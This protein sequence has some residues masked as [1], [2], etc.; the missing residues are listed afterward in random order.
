M[1]NPGLDAC[2]QV[3]KQ[4]ASLPSLIAEALRKNDFVPTFVIDV[5]NIIHAQLHRHDLDIVLRHSWNGFDQGIENILKTHAGWFAPFVPG[6]TI[7]KGVC[8]TQEKPLPNMIYVFD[9]VRVTDKRVNSSRFETRATAHLRIQQQIESDGLDSEFS[10]KDIGSAVGGYNIQAIDRVR[11]ILNRLG[12][13]HIQALAEAEHEM[14]I[15]MQMGVAQKALSYDTDFTALLLDGVFLDNKGSC[16]MGVL[17]YLPKLSAL[18]EESTLSTLLNGAGVCTASLMDTQLAFM[19]NKYNLLPLEVLRCVFRNDYGNTP[20]VG[21]PT[22]VDALFKVL[23]TFAP[24]SEPP[25]I[26][27]IFTKLST[28]LLPIV[29]AQLISSAKMKATKAENLVLAAAAQTAAD[30]AQSNVVASYLQT[31]IIS[32]KYGSLNNKDLQ[33]MC[34]DRKLKVGG[35]KNDLLMRLRSYDVCHSSATVASSIVTTP[36][37]I[38]VGVLPLEMFLPL[39]WVCFLLL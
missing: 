25:N 28:C 8:Y 24:S 33:S 37:D 15:L 21:P 1:G 36:S 20:G 26:A 29:N 35:N 5:S 34:R 31:P 14:Y 19:F 2:V 11:A 16:F 4:N 13:R 9:G 6:T 39:M 10:K 38:G 18:Q 22:G 12:M 23:Q 32:D 17:R 30:A 3:V 7:R 27:S